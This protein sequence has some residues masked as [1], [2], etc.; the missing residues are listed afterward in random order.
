MREHRKFRQAQGG[1][2]L[3]AYGPEP[4]IQRAPQVKIAPPPVG[5]K[6]RY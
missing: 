3:A 5:S 2:G 4:D 1:I 6:S